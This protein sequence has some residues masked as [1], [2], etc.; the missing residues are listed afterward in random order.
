MSKVLS[1][2]SSWYDRH[3]FYIKKQTKKDNKKQQQKSNKA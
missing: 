2:V 1:F 3:N